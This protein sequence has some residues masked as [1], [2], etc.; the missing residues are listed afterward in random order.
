MIVCTYRYGHAR[1]ILLVY[2]HD[3]ILITIMIFLFHFKIKRGFFFQMSSAKMKP[4]DL[5][6]CTDG[7]F[8]SGI[9]HLGLKVISRSLEPPHFYR[10]RDI[11][12][13]IYKNCQVRNVPWWNLKFQI[14]SRCMQII[15]EFK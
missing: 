8:D 7:E 3:S 15:I 10:K 1:K 4:P 14:L 5:L 2:Y 12:S 11:L 13:L 9:Q 6:K